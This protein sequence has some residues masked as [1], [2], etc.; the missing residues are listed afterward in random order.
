MHISAT[1][2]PG[3]SSIAA[4]MSRLASLGLSVNISEMDV[5]IRDV[6]G[7]LPARFN[8]QKSVYH[9]IVGMCVAEPR[10]DGV[11]FWGFTD[12]HSWVNGQFGADNPLLFDEQYAAKPAY[13]GVLDALWRR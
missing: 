4:N 13:Y 1:S 12:A 2:P 10:C 11:T 8:A 9:S 3:D 6:P 7:T 5:R